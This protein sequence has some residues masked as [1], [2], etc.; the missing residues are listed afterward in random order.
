MDSTLASDLGTQTEKLS[1]GASIALLEAK[2]K[3]QLKPWQVENGKAQFSNFLYELFD[4]D[5]A[6]LPLK[7]TYTGLWEQFQKLQKADPELPEL[8]RLTFI[9][10]YNDKTSN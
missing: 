3:K 4:R 10:K 9:L 1:T 5:N 2:L 6:E 7:G 8:I